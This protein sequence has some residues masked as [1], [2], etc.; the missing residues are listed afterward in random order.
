MT[1][2][3]RLLVC[4]VLLAAS[5]AVA[6]TEVEVA[7]TAC[8]GTDPF[9]LAEIDHAFET[10]IG[11]GETWDEHICDQN[12]L[13][14]YGEGANTK[15]SAYRTRRARTHDDQKQFFALVTPFISVAMMML[16]VVVAMVASVVFKQRKSLVADV[17]CPHCSL[18]M[19]VDAN[20]GARQMFC[21]SCGQPM[22]IVIVGTGKQA[23]PVAQ[24]VAA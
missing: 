8:D 24:V 16:A 11:Y 2:V 20:D 13:S 18:L 19:P 12:T 15:W 1:V 14:V 10:R 7:A 4:A 5:S 3:T 17:E 6:D 23:R 22:T 9:L 21:P